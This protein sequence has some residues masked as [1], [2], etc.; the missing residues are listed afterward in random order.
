MHSIQP[1]FDNRLAISHQRGYQDEHLFIMLARIT[2]NRALISPAK[3]TGGKAKK[4]KEEKERFLL[5]TPRFH[6]IFRS[7]DFPI[8]LRSPFYTARFTTD[9]TKILNTLVAGKRTMHTQK[10][11]FRIVNA[12]TLRI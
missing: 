2:D 5:P 6:D 4:K 9:D 7:N 8:F 1:R 11:R 3:S 12:K 10:N